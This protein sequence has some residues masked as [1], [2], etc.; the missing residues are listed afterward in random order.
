MKVGVIN[1]GSSSIKYE[2]FDAGDLSML[3]TGLIEKIGSADGRL[4][5]RRLKADGTFDE[6]VHTK[7]LANHREAVRPHGERESA[8]PDHQG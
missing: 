6:Q 2:V 8:R 3:A 7:P 1:S 5:Q 4:R